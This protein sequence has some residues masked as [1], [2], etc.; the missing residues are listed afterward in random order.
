MLRALGLGLAISLGLLSTGCSFEHAASVDYDHMPKQ[1][2]GYD[3]V[4]YV[5]AETWTPTVF[6]VF[7]ILPRQ[8]A[9]KARQLALAKAQDAFGADGIMDLTIHTETHSA[10]WWLWIFGW[11]ENHASATAVRGGS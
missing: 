8:N 5:H 11:V 4:G 3:I 6:Y 1:K 2:D 9:E 10:W 7:P